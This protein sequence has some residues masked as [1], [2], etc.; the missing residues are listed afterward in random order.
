MPF[1]DFYIM[2][3]SRAIPIL[4]GENAKYFREIQALMENA[5]SQKQWESVGEKVHAM[6]SKAGSKAWGF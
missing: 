1:N 4:S 3:K 2:Y 6:M 5:D